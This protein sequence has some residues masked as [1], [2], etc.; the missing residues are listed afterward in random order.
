MGREPLACVPVHPEHPHVVDRHARP[1]HRT[2]HPGGGPHAHRAAAREARARHAT[3]GED[4]RRPCGVH[5]RDRARHQAHHAGRR[6]VLVR[7]LALPHVVGGRAGL[8]PG[9]ELHRRQPV[10][11]LH[12]GA[13]SAPARVPRAGDGSRRSDPFGRTPPRDVHGEGGRAAAGSGGAPRAPPG[14]ARRHRRARPARGARGP[15]SI[16]ARRAGREGRRSRHRPQPRPTHRP[17]DPVV[18]RQLHAAAA[19]RRLR[20]RGAHEPVI[21]AP[22][23]QGGHGDE[24]AAIPEA[25]APAGSAPADARRR[26]RRGERRAPRGIREPFAVQPRVQPP[27]W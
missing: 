12:P 23:L 21:A 11:L 16:V 4:A 5:L 3:G 6:D 14:D 18:A 15:V 17:R 8:E 1:T 9:D 26:H 27:V 7:L 19:H 13:R 2:P 20:A 22:S 10:P 24:P 25:P